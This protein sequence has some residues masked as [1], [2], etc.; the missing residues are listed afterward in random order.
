MVRGGVTHWMWSPGGN[1][2][3][4]L[5][6]TCTLGGAQVVST[7]W[8]GPGRLSF[9]PSPATSTPIPGLADRKACVRGTGLSCL[10]VSHSHMEALQQVPDALSHRS[11]CEVTHCLHQVQCSSPCHQV[12]ETSGVL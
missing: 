12:T 4:G 11:S 2:T 1:A 6:P 7:G 9:L 8:A 10:F 3:A 5:D